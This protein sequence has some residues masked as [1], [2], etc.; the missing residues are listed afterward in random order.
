[1]RRLLK[2]PLELEKVK[3]RAFLFAIVIVGRVIHAVMPKDI[4][5]K[6]K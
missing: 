5:Q 1:M 6:K 3:G 4:G 2:L